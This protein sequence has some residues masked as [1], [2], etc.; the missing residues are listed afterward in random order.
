MMKES[1]LYLY[2]VITLC[3]RS[4]EQLD[5]HS[6][7]LNL[8]DL[9]S[10]KA[11]VR[12]IRAICYWYLLDLFARVPIITSTDKSINQIQQAERS[13]KRE[14]HNQKRKTPHAKLSVA[15]HHVRA[16]AKKNAQNDGHRPRDLRLD[17]PNPS[18]LIHYRAP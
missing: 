5:A 10:Y 17:G 1:W 14:T 18:I 16:Q 3:N 12:S 6:R 7:L 8:A 2:K 15:L 9:T 4:I 13:R 11:E